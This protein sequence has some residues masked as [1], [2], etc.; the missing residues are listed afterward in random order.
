MAV[1]HRLNVMLV[2]AL[3]AA[4]SAVGAEIIDDFAEGGWRIYSA[5]TPGQ[6]EAEKGRLLVVDL[7]GGTVTW[8]T[9]ATKR[10]DGID[11]A[12]TPYLVVNLAEVSNAFTIKLTGKRKDWGKTGVLQTTSPGLKVIDIP[13]ATKWEG[14]G[15]IHVTMYASGPESRY[16]AR[17]VKLTGTLT[18]E[19]KA[20][21]REGPKPPPKA[22]PFA[23]LAG[24]AARRGMKPVA[25]DPRDGERTVCVDPL[26]GHEVWRMTDHPAIE[27]HEYY[28]ILAWNANGGLMLFLS[29]RAGGSLWLM[30]A[31]GTGIHP[32]PQP[33]DGGPIRAPRWSPTR[34][35]LVYFARADQERVRVMTL[36]VRNGELGEVVSVPFGEAIG[37]RR[38][39]EMPPPHPDGRH[40]LLRYG[41]QDRLAT[42]LVVADAETGQC[43]QVDVGMQTHRVRFTKAADL[44]VFVNSNV[45]PEDPEKRLRTEWVVS[46]DG[47]KRQLPSGGGH[48]DWTPDGSWLGVFSGGGIWMIS[49]DGQTKK[50]LVHTGAG[51]HGGFSITTGRY[52]VADAPRPGPYGNLVYVTELAGGA[53]TPIAYHGSS[54][55]GWSSK[56]PDPEATHPAPICSPDETKI[57]YDS[58]LLGQPDVWVAVWKRPGTP[59]NVR[60]TGGTLSWG[61]P[62]LHREIAGYNV[63]R[64]V[65]GYW[66]LVKAGVEALS[67]AGL[68]AG[69]YAVSAQEWSGLESRYAPASGGGPT[70][71]STSPVAPGQ[72]EV[73]EKSATYVPIKWAPVDCPDL[74]HYNVYAVAEPHGAPSLASLAGSPKATRFTDWGRAPGTTFRY[75]ITAV[76]RQGHESLPSRAVEVTTDA[77]PDG[78]VRVELQ[79]EAGDV[80]APMVIAEDE[81]ASGGA[82]VHVPDEASD[83]A[84][85]LEGE[86]R[87]RF[88][89]PQ[90]GT[91]VF[92]GRA[93]GL[94]GESNSFFVSVDGSQPANWGVPVPKKGPPRFR[95]SRMAGL[96]GVPLKEGRHELVIASREDGAR[97]D[98]IVI[99]NDWD[100]EVTD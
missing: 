52:H 79:A 88:E 51:G 22:P 66:E 29:R 34:P 31:D 49:H 95:W 94:N 23:G 64:R 72:P 19:E 56:V 26:T 46:L 44:S 86:V 7:P 99:T 47:G 27:R 16:V 98:R 35:N 13:A 82:Y 96:E 59:R 40:F 3:L 90:H 33:A 14:S 81:S 87:M 6:L 75:R 61:A 45:D 25:C 97:I 17:W 50:E 91:Y 62:E 53:V 77:V 83:A 57:V 32:L 70:C 55:S 43:R 74:D 9:A 2:G 65:D 37:E 5:R 71:D 73:V 38:F 100:E 78:N 15:D 76:D 1:H 60:F 24:L 39:S 89:L 54:Y 92:W 10:F 11:L 30:N 4:L 12:A 20:A 42:L 67:L 85:V 58:D 69:T 84:Y 8:G 28:D 93:A 36:D 80:R 48:P 41:G 63:H 18:E 21:L 68:D